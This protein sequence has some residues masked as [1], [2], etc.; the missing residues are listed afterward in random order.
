MALIDTERRVLNRVR[1]IL[2]SNQLTQQKEQVKNIT[3]LM[4]DLRE[5]DR[6]NGYKFMTLQRLKDFQ[7]L[8]DEVSA[9]CE[10]E[11]SDREILCDPR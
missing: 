4:E 9:Q 1:N 5:L 6:D 8:L 7:S 10:V 2:R 11:I 3:T